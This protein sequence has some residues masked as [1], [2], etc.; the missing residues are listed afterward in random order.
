MTINLSLMSIK[1]HDRYDRRPKT[2]NFEG[3][4]APE[5]QTGAIMLYIDP[6][7]EARTVWVRHARLTRSQ[8]KKAQAETE[9]QGGSGA[10]Y[11]GFLSRRH[12]SPSTVL[13]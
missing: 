8:E 1:C 13:Y 2:S 4:I 5:R 12:P 9:E 3:R 6:V 7:H 11:S 10:T